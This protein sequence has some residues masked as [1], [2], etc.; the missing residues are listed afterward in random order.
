[1][2]SLD[3]DGNVVASASASAS[4]LASVVIIQQLCLWILL[5]L[6]VA[7]LFF[8]KHFIYVKKIIFFN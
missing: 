7:V 2:K 4:A 1:M 5:L 6:R 8:K 3:F